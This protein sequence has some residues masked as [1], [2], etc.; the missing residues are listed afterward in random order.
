KQW[1]IF[2]HHPHVISGIE[3][4]KIYSMGNNYIPH[5]YYFESYPATHYGLAIE[6]NT[7]DLKYDILLTTLSKYKDNYILNCEKFNSIPNEVLIHGKNFTN[8]KKL[9]LRVFSFNG[10]IL[11]L[12]KL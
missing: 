4:N 12:I 3:K 9:F 7:I 11:D 8:I 2:G 10:S 5:P 1:M 6:L